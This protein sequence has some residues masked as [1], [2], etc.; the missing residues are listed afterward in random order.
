VELAPGLSSARC[1]ADPASFIKQMKARISIGLKDSAKALEMGLRMFSATVGREDEPYRRR[2][3]IGA[4]MAITHIGPEP[5]GLR[6]SVAG[7]AHRNGSVVGMKPCA[8]KHMATYCLCEWVE[9]GSRSAAP[10][11]KHGAVD[12][13]TFAGVDLRL[14]VQ[15]RV[16]AILQPGLQG[17]EVHPPE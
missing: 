12:T 16:I 15:R 7:C 2:D 3:R 17:H 11:C 5:A 9:Q 10:S 1:F 4:R 14:P 13:D 8:R 6:P